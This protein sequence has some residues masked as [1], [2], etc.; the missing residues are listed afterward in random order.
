MI[1]WESDSDIFSTLTHQ[2]SIHVK[3]F[4]ARTMTVVVAFLDKH[5][6]AVLAQKMLDPKYWRRSSR[7][8]TD[9][10]VDSVS[11]VC[12]MFHCTHTF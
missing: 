4:H 11:A 2:I 12:L 3:C 8:I 10:R 6:L 5:F 1:I 7:Y 9:L